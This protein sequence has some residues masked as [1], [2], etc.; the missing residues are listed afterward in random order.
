ML[1]YLV[2]I[3]LSLKRFPNVL[4]SILAVIFGIVWP[5]G[6]LISVVGYELMTTAVELVLLICFDKLAIGAYFV[7]TAEALGF[8]LLGTSEAEKSYISC[9]W[10]DFVNIL[11]YFF[12]DSNLINI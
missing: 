2:S 3:T 9:V 7:R 4:L 6:F 11:N 8:N 1:V 5:T 12:L 10:N